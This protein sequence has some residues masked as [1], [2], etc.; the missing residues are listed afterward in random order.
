MWCLD[1]Q[2]LLHTQVWISGKDC[3]AWARW[4]CMSAQT[5]KWEIARGRYLNNH[6][7]MNGRGNAV[8]IEMRDNDGHHC[9]PRGD[10]CKLS[11]LTMS[12]SLQDW[13]TWMTLFGTAWLRHI[14]L[15]GFLHRNVRSTVLDWKTCN[16]IFFYADPILCQL[17]FALLN[18]A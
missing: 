16:F 18:H 17:E 1:W 7:Q 3:K 8:D 2:S 5:V 14:S 4:Y 9:D 13:K 12:H 10:A 11:C 15:F 6:L